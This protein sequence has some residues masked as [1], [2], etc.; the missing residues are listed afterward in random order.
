[1]KHHVKIIEAYQ[2]IIPETQL[3]TWVGGEVVNSI[4]VPSRTINYTCGQ[5]LVFSNKKSAKEF[6]KALG[7]KAVITTIK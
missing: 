7:G 2:E 3:E 6:I 5:V 4:T 1:M